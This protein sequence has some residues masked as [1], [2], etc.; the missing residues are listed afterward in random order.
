MIG[1]NNRNLTSFEVDTETTTRLME[2]VPKDTMLCALSG[3]SGPQD[4]KSYLENGVGAMLVGEALMRAKDPAKFIAKLLSGNERTA[5]EP[6]VQRLLLIKICGT[7]SA[8]AAATAIKSGADLIG[9]ILVIGTKRCVS[10]ETALQISKVVHETPKPQSSSIPSASATD[11]EEKTSSFFEHTAK[12]HLQH[13]KRALLVGVFRNPSPAYVLQRQPQQNLDLIQLHGSE[14]IEWAPLIP[15]PVVHSFN[16]GDSELGTRGY[17][18]MSLLDSG[19]GGIG[20]KIG[21]KKVVNELE[22]DRELRIMLAGGLN[23]DN[24]IE[25]VNEL[26]SLK[27]QVVGV[28]VSSGVETDG[29]QDLNKIEKFVSAAKRIRS[30]SLDIVDERQ[31]L[32]TSA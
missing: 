7:R 27:S 26:G 21:T 24:V 32:V 31:R 13:P 23:P 25:V 20:Q 9:I 1:V 12:H 30:D 19:A 8:E 18:S 22:K 14:P 5:V 17:H 6:K 4:I 10:T 3:I 2:S 16:P 28:D 15:C 11:N 29:K